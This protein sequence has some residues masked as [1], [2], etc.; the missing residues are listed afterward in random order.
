MVENNGSKQVNE[1]NSSNISNKFHIKKFEISE[2]Q[3]GENILTMASSKKYIFFLTE[4]NNIFLV[5]NESLEAINESY[6]L[7]KPKTK[8]KFKENFDKIWADLEGI[9]C[10]IRHNNTTYYFN[11]D[12]KKCVELAIFKGKEIC[13]VALD[14]RNTNINTTNFFLAVDYNNKIY[15]CRIDIE[16]DELS[17]KEK[18]NDKI[19]ELI[20]LNMSD[21]D[22]DEKEKNKKSKKPINDRIYGIKFTFARNKKIN[23]SKNSCYIIAVTRNRLYQF[24]GPG[25]SDF[26]QIFKKYKENET[27]LNYSWKY[28]PGESEFKVEFDILFLNESGDIKKNKDV[29]N[30]FGWRT[31]SGYCYG[32]FDLSDRG[33]PL[34]IQKLFIVPFQKI[35]NKGEMKINC[36]PISVVHTVNHIF[37][38]YEDCL[39]VFSKI[40]SNIVH[41]EYLDKKYDLM[42]LDQYAK[43]NGILLLSSKKEIAQISLKN[44]NVDIWRDYIYIKDYT[45]A[46]VFC[47][48]KLQKRI[49]RLD[50]EREFKINKITK[51]ASA[52]TYALSD[53]KFEIICLKY[54]KGGDFDALLAYLEF[55]KIWNLK[56]DNKNLKNEEILQLNLII[57]FMIEIYFIKENTDKKNKTNLMDDI[58]ALIRS[59]KK[60]II[61]ELIY[62]ILLDF[63]KFEE[64]IDFFS[65][66]QDYKRVVAHQINQGKI[67]KALDYIIEIAG[68]LIDDP[69]EY[70][71]LLKSLGNAF[72]E[73]IRD[74]FQN[75]PK[76]AFYFLNEILI[77]YNVEINNLIENVVIALMSR[78][79]KDIN[80]SKYK[81]LLTQEERKKFDEEKE[82]ILLNLKKLKDGNFLYSN[83][84]KQ[85]KGQINNINNLYILYLT[86]DP[87]NKNTLNTLLKNFLLSETN[88]KKALISFPLDYVNNLLKDNK[89]AYSLILALMEKYSEAIS[90]ILNRNGKEK[91]EDKDNEKKELETAEL[92]AN[93]A[94]GKRLKKDLWIQ[95]FKYIEEKNNK[96]KVNN[97]DKISQ[98]LKFINKSKVLKIED[99]FPYIPDS[100]NI[101]ELQKLT[102]EYNSKYAKNINEIKENIKSYNI[103]TEN[104]KKDI[105][106]LKKK[107]MEIKYNQF[108]CAICNEL[109][110]NKRIYLFPC[111]HMFDMDCIRKRLLD[112]ENTGLS[113]LHDDNLKID[114][115]FYQLGYIP[116][117]VFKE[118]LVEE[119]IKQKK[120]RKA[121]KGKGTLNKIGGILNQLKYDLTYDSSNE[122]HIKRTKKKNEKKYLPVLNEILCKSCVLC[123]NF[124]VDS[125]QLP[126]DDQS[127]EESN[128]D[129]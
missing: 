65:L 100:I 101:E 76:N 60:Y 94:P 71:N 88:N 82:C 72:S 77:Q 115:L 16:K 23:K 106:N 45:K 112:Y 11:S 67:D 83:I 73:N 120:M 127:K 124:L 10:I 105:N 32:D 12:R 89:I 125:V 43:D 64:Y 118:N 17:K 22:D 6:T 37:I 47:P 30:K 55:Y 20:I 126:L 93:K 5:K 9:H 122:D 31:A 52:N 24:K 80:K 59:N 69:K 68:Y 2:A 104:I 42:I 57:A 21:S 78:T 116:K 36:L 102:F 114:K 61:P 4:S 28:I 107:S 54:L 84:K 62:P 58:M 95:I 75:E 119:K 129:L 66:L 25:F 8:N 18:V 121:E 113:E 92:I 33:I 74:F 3:R 97:E 111:G 56:E 110:R 70:M 13:A 41:T 50:A 15:Q 96:N 79:N 44:E 128:F 90:Y 85:I 40:S 19:E 117:L 27:L 1:I 48:E 51:I 53:E 49:T 86:L 35:T 46:K 63:G 26:K 109:I 34:E 39:T 108:K 123:G 91:K 103:T 81:K 98:I 29:F 14:D 87:S 7:P 38:L 99:L